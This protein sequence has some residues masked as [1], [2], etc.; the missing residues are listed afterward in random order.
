MRAA[1]PFFFMVLM[2][3][4]CTTQAVGERCEQDQD[5]NGAGGEVCRSEVNPAAAC[6]GSQC[7]CCP[8][9]PDIART[10][11]ACAPRTTPVT[12]A[13][14]TDTPAADTTPA[15]VTTDTANGDAGADAATDANGDAGTD[16][17]MDA[18]TG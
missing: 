9:N 2:A 17:A 11:A 1:R 6:T 14:P 13:S 3:L 15:D 10:I 18:T 16:A 5:C 7:I 12:D 4:G 8:Q